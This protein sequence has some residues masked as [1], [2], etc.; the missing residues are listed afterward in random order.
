M[1]MTVSVAR[2]ADK[3]KAHCEPSPHF[4]GHWTIEIEE[5]GTQTT[6]T[7]RCVERWQRISV[8]FEKPDSQNQAFF[9]LI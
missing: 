8:V 1:A 5:A 9:W 4:Q 7:A 3:T 2:G 6:E